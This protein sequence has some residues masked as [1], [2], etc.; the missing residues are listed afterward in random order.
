MT[1]A[2][3]SGAA[4]N[5]AAWIRAYVRTRHHAPTMSEIYD[6]CDFTKL[7]GIQRLLA[8]LEEYGRT[9]AATNGGAA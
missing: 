1:D 7:G 2:S 6:A 9:I 8:A 5:I 4:P 3:P